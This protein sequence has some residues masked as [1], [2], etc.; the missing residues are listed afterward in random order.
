MNQKEKTSARVHIL[1]VDDNEPFLLSLVEGLHLHDEGLQVK[2][3]PNG[4]EAT[5]ILSSGPVDLVITDLKMPVMDGFELLAHMMQFYPKIPVIVM[6]AFGTPEIERTIQKNGAV[7]YLEKPLDLKVI[8]AM[9]YECLEAKSVDFLSEIYLPSFLRLL[10]LER[11]SCLLTVHSQGRRG[12]LHFDRGKLVHAETEEKS[13]IDAVFEIIPWENATIEIKGKF[14]RHGPTVQDDLDFLIMES[15]R[16]ADEGKKATQNGGQ[17]DD[18]G[19]EILTSLIGFEQTNHKQSIK[20]DHMALNVKRFQ[21]AIETLKENVGAG[22]IATD[23]WS[24]SDGQPIVG[25]NSQPKA[26]ALFNQITL[27]LTRSLKES[28]FPA[29]GRLYN[30]ELVDNKMVIV[31]NIGDYQWGILADSS[32]V[33]LGL[34]LNVAIPNALASLED[35]VKS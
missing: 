4:R 2:T 13:G 29:L 18:S 1:I 31:M 14:K 16:L 3:A 24:P 35:A 25:Y 22:L 6:T 8:V 27:Y 34:L 20:E 32:K 15:M 19:L 21:E 33:S 23:I 26:C 5:R 9:I 12:I 17:L 30:I 28:G 10:E 7:S 11:K